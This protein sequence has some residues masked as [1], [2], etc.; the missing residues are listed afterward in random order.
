M[1]PQVSATEGCE[2]EAKSP[3][4]EEGSELHCKL[5]GAGVEMGRKVE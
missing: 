3:T 1:R 4:P 2:P 5:L